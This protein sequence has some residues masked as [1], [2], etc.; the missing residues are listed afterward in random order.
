M[1]WISSISTI[2]LSGVLDEVLNTVQSPAASTGA[3]FHAAIKNGKFH[4]TIWPTTPI[5]SRMTILNK[6]PSSN[7]FE[8]CCV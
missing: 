3:S 1:S 4:G 7:L 6:L 2:T 5:G 8:P